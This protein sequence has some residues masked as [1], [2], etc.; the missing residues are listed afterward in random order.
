MAS[1]M[2]ESLADTASSEASGIEVGTGEEALLV[3]GPDSPSFRS[4]RRLG[5][6]G[7]SDEA[8]WFVSSC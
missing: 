4:A 1:S 6:D 2:A 3:I 8:D 5:I 7:K